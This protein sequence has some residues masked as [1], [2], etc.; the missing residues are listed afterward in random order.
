MGAGAHAQ[1]DIKAGD[2][3]LGWV[4]DVGQVAGA[5]TEIE[6]GGADGNGGDGEVIELGTFAALECRRLIVLRCRARESCFNC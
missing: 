2:M 6:H 1:S 4:G 3:P 5:A